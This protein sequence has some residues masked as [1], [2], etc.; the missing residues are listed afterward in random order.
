MAGEFGVTNAASD[1]Q[2][3]A[4]PDQCVSGAIAMRWVARATVEPSEET[5]RTW[6]STCVRS[7]EARNTDSGRRRCSQSTASVMPA[8]IGSTG[9]RTSQVGWPST[10]S[11]RCAPAI[12]LCASTTIAR[13]QGTPLSSSDAEVASAASNESVALSPSTAGGGSVSPSSSPSSMTAL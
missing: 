11:A 10:E 6:M 4:M 2:W 7:V 8:S 5:R 9:R 12:R 1:S 13:T 3:V